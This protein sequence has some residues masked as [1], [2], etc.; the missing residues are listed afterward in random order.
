MRP[1][2]IQEKSSRAA[3]R[4]ISIFEKKI[5]D[6]TLQ[7]GEPLPPEREIT[8]NYQV[9]RTV[10]REAVKA[11]ANKGLIDAKPRFRPTVKAPSTETAVEVVSSIVDRLMNSSGG[12]KNLF[13]SRIMIE[14][15]LAR[16]AAKEARGDQ[17]QDLRAAL[18]EN[19]SAIENSEAFYR[20]DINFHRVLYDI[21]G[22]PIFPTLHRAYTDW[23]S[24]HWTKMPRSPER[25]GRNFRYHKSIFDAVVSKDPDAAEAALREHLDFAWA[26]VKETFSFET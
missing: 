4:L 16:H 2:D 20:T 18:N 26:Q 5:L 11:L 25:N 7:D 3:D 6:G 22:N 12:V 1:S 19:E 8:E 23:L 24:D 17:L 21:P 10:V 13:D 9:S 14:V 15:S